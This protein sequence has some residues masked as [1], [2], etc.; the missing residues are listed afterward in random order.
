MK[1][2]IKNGAQNIRSRLGVERSSRY[3]TQL[4][5][6]FGHVQVV[7]LLSTKRRQ[8]S[9]RR[10]LRAD[11]NQLQVGHVTVEQGRVE[12]A[13]VEL[14]RTNQNRLGHENIRRTKAHTRASNAIS[15]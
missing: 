15:V 7:D 14:F 11:H 9:E 3:D 4:A 6:N 12:Y 1:R 13:Q 10:R 8:V 5:A 2:Y